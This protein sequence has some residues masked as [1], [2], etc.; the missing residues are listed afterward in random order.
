[1]LPFLLINFPKLPLPVIFG[2]NKIAGFSGTTVAAFQYM[3]R[4][5]FNFTLL[6]I[7]AF[8]AFIASYFGAKTV[9]NINS[10]SLEPLPFPRCAAGLQP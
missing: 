6:F 1:M 7:I 8:F 4:V 9:S 3:K 10:E 2:T 5:R